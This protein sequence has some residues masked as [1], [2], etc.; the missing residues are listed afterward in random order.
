M[1]HVLFK[2]NYNTLFIFRLTKIILKYIIYTPYARISQIHNLLKIQK[3][4]IH[5]GGTALNLIEI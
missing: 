1:I 5:C 3:N 2:I 4:K